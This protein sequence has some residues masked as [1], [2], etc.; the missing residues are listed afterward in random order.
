MEPIKEKT[1]PKCSSEMKNKRSCECYGCRCVKKFGKNGEKT[2]K[3]RQNKA[4][5]HLQS[6]VTI[7]NKLFY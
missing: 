7:W 6:N 4:L 2:R 3:S 1:C 5:K